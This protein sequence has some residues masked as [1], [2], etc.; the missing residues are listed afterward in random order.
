MARTNTLGNFLTDVANAIREKKGT[1]EA[2]QASNFDTEIANLPSG[3]GLDWSALGFSDTPDSI[4]TDYAYSKNIQDNWTPSANLGNKFQ[5]NTDLVYMPTVDTSSAQ[6]TSS[7]FRYC[8]KLVSVAP[9]NLENSTTV[10][11]MFMGD[12]LLEDLPYFNLPKATNASGFIQ[13]CN[14]LTDESLDNVLKTCISMTL[15]EGTKTFKT[16]TNNTYYTAE[17]LQALPHYQNFI[18]AGWTIGY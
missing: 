12:S 2:I 16:L 14:N 4:K 11:Q 15:Y 17:R 1:S 7:M 5:N 10:N 18:D 6:I 8:S 3:G 13:S 9:L